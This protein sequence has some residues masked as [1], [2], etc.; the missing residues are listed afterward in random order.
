[1]QH[2]TPLYMDHQFVTVNTGPTSAPQ[3]QQLP[4]DCSARHP[5]LNFAQWSVIID[6]YIH[7]YRCYYYYAALQYE[8]RAACCYR[9][10]SIICLSLTIVSPAKMPEP[11][12]TLFG[13]W[14]RFGAMWG[15]TL[16]SPRAYNWTARVQR[17]CG[18]T[19]TY[20]SQFNYYY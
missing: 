7:Y 5:T 19:S 10:S 2:K 1:M 12:V 4:G 18:P 8:G 6:P 9:Q 20:L 3:T 17:Q 11:I 14:T 15:C 16:N 13:L